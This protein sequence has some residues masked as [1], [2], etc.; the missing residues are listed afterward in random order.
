MH[1]S[2]NNLTS[3]EKQIK[4]SF[5][6]LAT[7]QIIA[8]SKTF[9][10]N[11]IKPLIDHGHIHFGEN[12]V[13]ESVEKW[14]DLKNFSTNVKLHMIGKLQTNKVKYVIPLF[15]YIHSLDNLKLAEKISHEQTKR[16]KRL[17]I[18]I[19]V[20]VGNEKQKSGIDPIDLIEFYNK[21]ITDLKLDVVGLMCIPPQKGDVKKY[22][23]TMLDF[24]NSLGVKELSMGMSSD[25]MEAI[26]HGSTFVRIGSKIFGNRN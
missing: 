9:S 2:I 24:K 20:N 8:V 6:Q 25:Y 11:E 13:Q 4:S 21:C 3:I 18:F 10:V 26:E 7:P 12:K 19:Q 1:N 16:N 22:F 23:K 5:N 17:K 15:D 14:T